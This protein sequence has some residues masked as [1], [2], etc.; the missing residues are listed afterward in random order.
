MADKPSLRARLRRAGRELIPSF[1]STRVEI[2]FGG[3]TGLAE[4]KGWFGARFFGTSGTA[5][6]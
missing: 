5:G 4:G 1:V 2:G 3:P 6:E